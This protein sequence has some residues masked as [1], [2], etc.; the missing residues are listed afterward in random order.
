VHAAPKGRLIETRI[1]LR[2]F[3]G[4]GANLAA[5]GQPLR[6]TAG[7]GFVA[8]L[9]SVRIVDKAGQGVCPATVR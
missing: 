1:P 2:C 7:S 3:K 6:L 9:R 8:T 5:V 4:A